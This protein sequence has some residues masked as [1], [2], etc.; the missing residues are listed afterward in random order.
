MAKLFVLATVFVHLLVH[1]VSTFW[2]SLYCIILID[3]NIQIENKELLYWPEKVADPDKKEFFSGE[4]I[5]FVKL[6]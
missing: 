1:S 4:C 3:T 5:D 6:W 2:T